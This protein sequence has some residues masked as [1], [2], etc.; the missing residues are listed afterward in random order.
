MPI[1]SDQQWICDQIE[2]YKQVQPRYQRM[3][4]IIQKI[5]EKACEKMAPQAIIQTRP[6]SIPSFAEKAQR[7][8]N[9][10]RD[11]LQRMTDLSGGRVIT[12][13]QDEVKAVCEFIE[14]NF[15]I[16][17][18]NSVDVG[19][20][21]KPSE[22][23]YRSVHYIVQFKR[24]V[25]PNDQVPVDV[26]DEFYPDLANPMK[27]EIQVRTVL[28]HA[29]AGFV[30]DRVYKGAFA[31][32]PKWER[33]LAV[34]AGMVE[35]IDGSF[36]RIQN[37][38]RAY[39]ANYGA[40]L[41]RDQ[42]TSE[43]AILETVLTCDPQNPELAH[44]IG[45]LYMELGEL[46]KAID[47]FEKYRHYEYQPI[48]RDLGVVLCKISASNPK[49]SQYEL[50]Q[51]CLQRA[52]ELDKQD[53]DALSSL[54]G[55][56]KRLDTEKTRALYRQ[57]FEVDPTD[58]YAVSNYLV[59][60][61]IHQQS[62][63]P[64]SLMSPSIKAAIQRC[65]DQIN[66]G[67]NLPWAYYNLGLFHLLSNKPY[68]ALTAYMLAVEHSSTEWM[69]ETSLNL[70]QKLAA[71]QPM[72]AGCDWVIRL[73][74]LILAIKYF[75]ED[76]LKKIKG[77]AQPGAAFLEPVIIIAGG[78]SP[79][80]DV[81]HY[82]NLMTEAFTDFEGTLISGGTTAGVSGLTGKIRA[83]HPDSTHAIGYI[84]SVFP[85]GTQ[86]D[87]NY[88]EIR[89]TEGQDFSALEPL[90]YWTDMLAAG[91]SPDQVKLIGINGGEISSFEYHLALM[92]G[93]HVA[94][95]KS[96]GRAVSALLS[97]PY[98]SKK[99]LLFSLSED[100]REL[101]AFVNEPDR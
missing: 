37:G 68:E 46:Q 87:K 61:I 26:E 24:G 22:F 84:P 94:V 69:V 33:E 75:D 90:Q 31:V 76:S 18:E 9:K 10:Y 40:Y 55:T 27:A 99:P 89:T 38:L 80:S 92:L 28:E 82:E 44:R 74:T 97:D 5:L 85:S 72:I 86:T 2:A 53:T 11:P 3:T 100:V 17:V 65:K 101:K 7:K 52:C 30:H 48:L 56:W 59:Y 60:E 8:K 19:Q 15:L 96:S 62:L 32:P 45:K 51:Q 34:L 21:L 98:W 20:R 47:L 23:G 16:D 64:A 50:G 12:Q 63:T 4:A 78:T 88:N 6:K 83:F 67:M 41:N 81:D 1:S 70:L 79:D 71:V 13:S 35:Q 39:A 25:F 54:A 73:L 49:S 42:I 77:D 57:A 95:I 66:V 93:A 91:V 36:S 29:W 43:I 58:P 14:K